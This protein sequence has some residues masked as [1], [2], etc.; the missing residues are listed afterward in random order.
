MKLNPRDRAALAKRLLASTDP[1]V[2]ATPII[3]ASANT[4]D[5]RAGGT[6]R[7]TFK[8][9][10]SYH[11]ERQVAGIGIVIHAR[12]ASDPPSKPG[13][14]VEQIAELYAGV[15]PCA[16]EKFA[17]LR[18]LEVARQR[19]YVNVS[20]RTDCNDLRR[21]LKSDNAANHGHCRNGLDGL[22]LRYAREFQEIHFPYHPRRKNQEAHRLARYAVSE[23][24][25]RPC[26]EIFVAAPGKIGS[27]ELR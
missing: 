12:N 13:S 3:A 22:I 23:L 19:G 21:R 10:A 5:P 6:L 18:A 11:P 15:P 27:S 26:P 16:A 8:V 4:Q 24:T 20:V 1:P 14:V 9:D 7:F 17:I 25:P 2:D